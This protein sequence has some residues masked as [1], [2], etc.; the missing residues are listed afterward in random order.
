VTSSGFKVETTKLAHVR[1]R[2]TDTVIVAGGG[3][4]ALRR[5]VSDHE[6]LAFARRAAT[7]AKRTA[8]VCTGA[9]VLAAAGIL[10]GKRAATHWS[11][12]AELA[13]FRPA[14][15]VD[16]NAIYVQ[17]GRIW[18]SAGVTT[19]IDMALA[20][21][22]EDLGRAVSDRVAARLVLY[23]R[24]PGFQSQFTDA[25][26]SQRDAS[27]PLGVVIQRARAQLRTLDVP[28]LARLAGMSIRTF[29]RRCLEA[30]DTTPRRLLEKLRVEQARTLLTSTSRSHKSIAAACGF[31][32]VAQLRVACE[33]ELGVTPMSV[34][35]HF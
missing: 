7:T 32:S 5:A 30:L 19:G 16:P 17:D 2:R 11:S 15:T 8:S 18:T 33:R 1:L 20:M 25:L 21:V 12:C 4:A 28:R 14:V 13:A 29:H 34:R 23:A 22:E 9:F 31:S 10:D 27:D 6:L 26:V 24:R 3:D 35:Q